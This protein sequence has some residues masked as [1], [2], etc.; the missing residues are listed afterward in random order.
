MS[1][2]STA[3]VFNEDDNND[4]SNSNINRKR[5]SH[6]R[7]Q[8]KFP[9]QIV[10]NEKVN[11]VLSS[12]NY[13]QKAHNTT[14]AEDGDDLGDFNP[15]ENPISS[16]VQKTKDVKESMINLGAQPQPAQQYG[17]QK[18]SLNN[19]Q[20]NYGDEKTSYEYY[21]R[22]LPNYSHIPEPP[23]HQDSSNQFSNIDEV[24]F[25]QFKNQNNDVLIEKL[26][27]MIHLLEESHDEKT[28]SV[29]EEVILYSFLGIF[30]IFIV[31]S[32]AK[33]GKYTR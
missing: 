32:F 23:N 19:Y 31:D 9:D 11:K 16:G 22:F 14:E 15:P 27:Y 2:A 8:K 10:D 4:N 6:N 1:L 21:K 3:A 7:T 24:K 28:H 33:I 12:M 26:N 13:I 18:L 29:T 25:K 5:S 17:D 30:I 20:T